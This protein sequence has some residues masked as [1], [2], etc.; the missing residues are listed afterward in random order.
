MVVDFIYL[1]KQITSKK[2]LLNN[3]IHCHPSSHLKRFQID[4]NK[5]INNSFIGYLNY[6][7][8]FLPNF[9]D[10]KLQKYV[11]LRN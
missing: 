3:I 8:R 6:I 4:I 7:G 5:S 9:I 1:I 2:G 10:N 11:T